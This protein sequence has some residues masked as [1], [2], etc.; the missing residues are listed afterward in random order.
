VQVLL[1]YIARMPCTDVVYCCLCLHLWLC[2]GYLGELCKHRW[3]NCQQVWVVD[4]YCPNYHT[5]TTILWLCGFCPG[6]PGWASTKRNIHRFTPVMVINH[7]L[8]ASYICYDPWHPPCS[9]YVPYSL[10]P[11]SLSRFSLV[12]FFSWHLP[13]LTQSLSSF[14]STCPYHCNLFCCSMEIMSNFLSL[15]PL[16]GTLSCSLT[17]HIHLTILISPHWSATSFSFLI[18][19]VNTNLE[20]VDK[21][22]YLGD[23]L[24]VD[25]DADAA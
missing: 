14:R 4:S 3:T 10:F 7:P 9:I 11:Q 15:D 1:G 21:F 12:Y 5:T 20:L 17:P 18:G 6:Q 23:M 25:G 13:L 8:S 22:C 24:S 16:L 19:Q 2:V